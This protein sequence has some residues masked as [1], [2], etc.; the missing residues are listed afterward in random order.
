MSLSYL[1][2]IHG[3]LRWFNNFVRHNL[4]GYLPSVSDHMNMFKWLFNKHVKK[5][6]SVT[7]QNV[8]NN[9]VSIGNYIWNYFTWFSESPIILIHLIDSDIIERNN[10]VTI[11]NSAC[12][13]TGGMQGWYLVPISIAYAQYL[14]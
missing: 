4:G 9:I 13:R 10:Q 1:I 14:K 3:I 6:K 11:D 5:K 2:C 8:A 12:L 7:R